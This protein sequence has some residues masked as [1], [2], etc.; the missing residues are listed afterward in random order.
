MS[1]L[2]PEEAPKSSVVV[3]H[4]PLAIPGSKAPP[5]GRR[6]V[7]R[8]Y[9]D[10]NKTSRTARKRAALTRTQAVNKVID[11]LDR[12]R[13]ARTRPEVVGSAGALHESVGDDVTSDLGRPPQFPCRFVILPMEAI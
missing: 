11:D 12:L 9:P 2:S 4:D 1:F 8:D 10:A 6:K 13:F 3:F 5:G 7:R